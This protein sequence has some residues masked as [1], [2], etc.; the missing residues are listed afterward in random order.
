MEF[1]TN[2][3][4]Y[5]QVIKDLKLKVVNGTLEL[6][7]KLPSTKDLAIEYKI[8]PNTA[9][10]IYKTMEEEEFCYTKRGIGTYLFED[11]NRIVAYRNELATEYLDA[12]ITGM[13]E[14]GYSNNELVEL[15]TSKL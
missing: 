4:I 8:N 5:L 9:S 1:K 12:F 14:L 13:M 3:P 15:I 7:Q 2:T 6:G 11:P 10:R